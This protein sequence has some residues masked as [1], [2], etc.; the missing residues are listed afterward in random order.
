M[1]EDQENGSEGEEEGEMID[2]ANLSPEELQ[3]LLQE[4]PELAEQ[5][6]GAVG[7]DEDEDEDEDEF[8]YE[9]S[10]DEYESEGEE[11]GEPMQEVFF[12]TP[13]FIA[14]YRGWSGYRSESGI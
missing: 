2:L 6:L 12:L 9:E 3:R 7:D 11:E 4:H 5:F 1:Y 14:K 8:D 13:K 10:D